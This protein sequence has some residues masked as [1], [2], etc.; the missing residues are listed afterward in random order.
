MAKIKIL[1]VLNELQTTTVPIENFS[2][3]D[4]TVYDKHVLLLGSSDPN[5]QQ[6]QYKHVTYH[7]IA[8]RR[9]QCIIALYRF[10]RRHDFDIVHTHHTFSSLLISF[11]QPIC[12]RCHIH[13][14]H[15]HFHHYR[16]RQKLAFIY[17]MV[18]A[19]KVIANSESTRHSLPRVIRKRKIERIYNGVDASSISQLPHELSGERSLWRFATCGRLVKQKDHQ[20]LIEA[21]YQLLNHPA[22]RQQPCELMI[23]G[24]GAERD[25]IEHQLHYYQIADQVTLTGQLPKSQVYHLLKQT[26]VFIMSS[27]WEGFGNAVVEAMFARCAIIGTDIAVLQEV[28][29]A[30]NGLFFRAGHAQS[31]QKSMTELV[32]NPSKLHY[33]QQLAYQRAERYYSLNRCIQ[34]HDQLYRTLCPYRKLFT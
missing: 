14:M 30:H 32:S 11:L 23:I 28:I 20:T 5:S 24:D 17:T 22:M 13:T 15:N 6:R 29:G 2:R 1:A 3:L 10:L 27:L 4:E 16:W 7:V 18:R 8:E 25:A 12:I 31:L 33:Y 26:D 34:A 21:F 9:W 19:H